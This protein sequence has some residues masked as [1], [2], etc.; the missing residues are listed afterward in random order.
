VARIAGLLQLAEGGQAFRRPI[1]EETL[2]RAIKLGDYFAARAAVAFDLLGDGETSNAENLLAF[3]RRKAEKSFT[4]R[5]LHVA[6]P[7]AGSP[8]LRTSPP[9]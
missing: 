9:L 1:T 5:Q 6:L 7:R 4:I 2:G 3:L 8:P